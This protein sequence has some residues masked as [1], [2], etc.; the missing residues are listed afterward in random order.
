M[1]LGLR[2]QNVLLTGASGVLGAAAARALAAE[3]AR[4]ALF[5]RDAAKLEPLAHALRGLGAPLVSI[6][7][8][9][10]ADA[11]STDA[12]V[13]RAAAA[14]GPLDVLVAA[15]GAA[16]GGLFWEI[17]D[18]GGRLAFNQFGLGADGGGQQA[19]VYEQTIQYD[20]FSQMTSRMGFHWGE[21]IGFTE[22]YINRRLQNGDNAVWDAAGN[23]M[24]TGHLAVS[25][26][27]FTDNY[28]VASGRRTGNFTSE[29]GTFGSR[30]N[31]IIQ[32]TI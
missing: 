21:S 6:V 28:I 29:R 5:G 19:R 27:D 18:A 30:L 31:M 17:D 23:I 1:D 9:D 16:Q 3:G 2:D 14:L 11:A 32:V 13:E 22:S 10:L 25:P 12:A 7:Q 26:N 8:G 24:A 4:L 15:A 20:G